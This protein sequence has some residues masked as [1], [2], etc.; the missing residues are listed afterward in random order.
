MATKARRIDPTIGGGESPAQLSHDSENFE[1]S[2]TRMVGW[3]VELWLRTQAG[4]FKAIEP[5]A[6]GWIERQS[7]AVTAAFDTVEKLA[8]CNDLNEVATVQRNWLEGSMRR[9]DANLH[10]L[11]D[12]AVAL[13]QEAVSATRYAAQSSSEMAGVAMPPAARQEHAIE[14][15][16]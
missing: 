12:Q 9:L 16:A 10:A 11:A 14:Q 6:T 3:P 15:A 5:M 4:I 13:S 7:E 8:H 1:T 2:F